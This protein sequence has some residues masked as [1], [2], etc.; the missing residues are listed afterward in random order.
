ME[1]RTEMEIDL[2]G[3][4]L[5]L[6]T[7]IWIIVVA[8]LVFGCGGFL[9]TKLTTTPTY[10]ASSQVYVNQSK[11]GVNNYD[12][13]AATQLRRDC[14]VIIQGELVTREVV[15]RMNLPMSAQGLAAGLTVLSDENTRILTISYTDVNPKRAAAI[16]DCVCQVADEEIEKVMHADILEQLY[17]T[18]VPTAQST[19]SIKRNT[20]AVAAIGCVLSLIVIIVVFLL[21]D[22]IRTEDDVETHLGLSTLAAIPVSSELKVARGS[23]SGKRKRSADKQRNP[24]KR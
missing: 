1:N 7:K 23:R 21:D 17:K 8:T 12:L 15:K 13:T 3:L 6:K 11:E 18:D 19:A 4:L 9:W 20:I 22:T 14:A 10:T 16:V 24:Q 2:L 5:H